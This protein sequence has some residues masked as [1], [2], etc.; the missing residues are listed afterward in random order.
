[1]LFP[2]LGDAVARRIGQ[3]QVRRTIIGTAAFVLAGLAVVCTQI[4]LDWLHPLIAA[5]ARHDPDLEGFD[6]ASLRPELA[7]HGWLQ[8]GTIVG[9]PNWR[10][11][12]KIAVGLGPDVTVLALSSDARQFGFAQPA[13]RYTGQDI[14]VLAVDHPKRAQ[15]TLSHEFAQ[16]RILGTVSIRHAGRDM[17]KVTVMRGTDL[18]G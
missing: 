18:K 1:M 5:V 8:P 11:A 4:R 3:A 6:W 15:Q 12:G 14:L 17:G 7:A 2:L 10:D 9:V 13:Q 16:V